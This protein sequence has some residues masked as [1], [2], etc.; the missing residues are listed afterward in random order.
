MKSKSSTKQDS[1]RTA[2]FIT[3]VKRDKKSDT[4]Y[5]FVTID[6]TYADLSD[7]VMIDMSADEDDD[8]FSI[9]VNVNT[10]S[11]V[12]LDDDVIVSGF[13]DDDFNATIVDLDNN[14]DKI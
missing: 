4:V 14:T 11:F 12:S 3:G 6:N 1:D 9:D 7:A 5:D 13:T 10:D 2:I 8:F